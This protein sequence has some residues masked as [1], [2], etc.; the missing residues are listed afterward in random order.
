MTKL[1][2]NQTIKSDFIYLF[3]FFE[4]IFW[5]VDLYLNEARERVTKVALN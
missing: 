2:W 3:F 4:K 5:G 1:F